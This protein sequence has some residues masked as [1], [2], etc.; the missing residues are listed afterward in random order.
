MARP[1]KT[2]LDYFPLDTD[3]FSDEKIVCIAG[4][5]GIQGQITVISLL[6]A[7]YRNGYYIEWN[8]M[9]QYRL[10]RD[11]PGITAQKLNEIVESL[12]NWGFF[13][14]K[15]FHS[16]AILT[17]RGI[18]AR[19]FEITKKRIQRSALPY[20]IPSVSSSET[21]VSEEETP[22]SSEETTHA[23][24]S[25]FMPPSPQSKKKSTRETE[26]HISEEETAVSSAETQV[27]EE[28]T[29]QSKVNKIKLNKTPPISPG[30]GSESGQKKDFKFFLDTLASDVTWR[31]SV[32]ASHSIPP[33]DIPDLLHTFR[34]WIISIGEES[35]IR[36]LADAKRRFTYWL[37]SAKRT[38]TTHPARPSSD[39][40]KKQRDQTRKEEELRRRN[41]EEARI[42]REKEDGFCLHRKYGYPPDIPIWKVMS[43][44]WRKANPPESF[45][46]RNP[47]N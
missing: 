40:Q 10:L 1:K 22:V 27:S 19:Y 6:C 3:L 14:P 38:D 21:N 25:P 24:S 17:S 33:A 44:E 16:S 37:S 30:G 34:H 5:H 23:N 42:E 11:L 12:V 31:K 2:G 26:N 41:Q 7:I 28:F 47:S 15:L 4:K 45:A 20:L 43:E 8:E 13:D 39:S 46:S 29:P 32:S 36:T 35:T 9:V 18:Q